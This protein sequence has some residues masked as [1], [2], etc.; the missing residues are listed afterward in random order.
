M[1]KNLVNA[2]RPIAI[3]TG[4]AE[5]IQ[6]TPDHG[7]TIPAGYAATYSTKATNGRS[8]APLVALAD[9]TAGVVFI[10]MEASNKAEVAPSQTDAIDGTTMM[11]IAFG[12]MA[13][14][15][16]GGGRVKVTKSLW[17]SDGTFAIGDHVTVTSAG[18]LKGVATASLDDMW[19]FGTI[20]FVE[21]STGNE[22]IHFNFNS[23]GWHA[24]A[25]S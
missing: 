3:V 25:V 16:G 4:P 19:V 12:A 24:P 5:E 15:Q 20:A 10:A 8:M 18:K 22:I 1:P 6:V 9:E 11:N 21:G 14:I 17:D 13:C 2:Y 7:E 23:N